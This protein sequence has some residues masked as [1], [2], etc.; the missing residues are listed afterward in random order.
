[1]LIIKINYNKRCS[2]H[3][4]SDNN[5]HL[6]I[7]INCPLISLIIELILFCIIIK[8]NKKYIINLILISLIILFVSFLIYKFHFIIPLIA[9]IL[10]GLLESIIELFI[11]QVH[12]EDTDPDR[13]VDKTKDNSG[14]SSIS[15]N[16]SGSIAAG[17][18]STVTNNTA[19]NI[20]SNTINPSLGLSI[21]EYIN[22]L[23]EGINL[24]TLSPELKDKY[25]DTISKLGG[26]MSPTETVSSTDTILPLDTIS[27][28]ISE[29]STTST[30]Q[31][32]NL[33][34]IEELPIDSVNTTAA[35]ENVSNIR[36]SVS[37][38]LLT[39]LNREDLRNEANDIKT[40]QGKKPVLRGLVHKLSNL[41]R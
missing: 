40:E 12:C 38:P 37:M 23:K 3:F 17:S 1:M 2:N 18:N 6:I 34:P 10:E 30:V 39:A 29:T 31:Q 22:Y 28:I 16:N 21:S 9:G 7:N 32:N 24:F 36:R 14:P 25:S 19:T 33:N 8:M 41:F 27:E 26:R 20:P 11:P 13:T 4:Y 5:Y 15:S 35:M